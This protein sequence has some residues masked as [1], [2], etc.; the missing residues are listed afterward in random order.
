MFFEVNSFKYFEKGIY[1]TLAD[2]GNNP[3]R[4]VFDTVLKRIDQ[5]LLLEFAKDLFVFKNGY[6]EPTSLPMTAC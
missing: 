4:C 5:V 2:S 3:N 1:E 6:F